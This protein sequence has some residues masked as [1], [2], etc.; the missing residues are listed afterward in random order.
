LSS[1]PVISPIWMTGAGMVIVAVVS[2]V[3][4]AI[5]E[6]VTVSVTLKTPASS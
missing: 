3:A 4:I 5:N 2:S 1:P 6:S